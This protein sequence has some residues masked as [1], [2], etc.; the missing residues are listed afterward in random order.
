MGN[1]EGEKSRTSLEKRLK[2]E[3]I[4]TTYKISYTQNTK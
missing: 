4:H 2:K 1:F 3:V